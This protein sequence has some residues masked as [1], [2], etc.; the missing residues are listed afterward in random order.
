MDVVFQFLRNLS[1][2]HPIITTK[3]KSIIDIHTEK[4]KNPNIILKIVIISEEKR[5]KEGIKRPTKA[6]P[7]QL[8]KW[9]KEL[10]FDNYL[11]CKWIKCSN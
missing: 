8:T 1:L 7:K 10:H 4:K 11:K 2:L 3:Q 5:T 9:Q 6:N